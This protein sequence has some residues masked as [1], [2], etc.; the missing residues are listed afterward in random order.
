MIA[1]FHWIVK[2]TG[3]LPQKLIFRTKVYYEDKSV[4]SRRIKGK[5][6]LASNHTSLLDYAVIMF[7]FPLRTFRCLA[8]EVLYT[9][10][11]LMRLLLGA[12]GMIRVDRDTNDFSFIDRSRR[13]LDKNGVIEIYPEARL[14]LPNETRPLPFKPSAV[15]LALET[16]TPIIPVYSTGKLFSMERNRV[17]IGKPLYLRDFLDEQQSH[18]ENIQELT[19][20]LRGKIIELEQQLTEKAQKNE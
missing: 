4:Q 17:I 1:L 16:D 11:I 13:I 19:Q 7:L 12:L 6:I 9:K 2:I 3:W 8:A 18:A 10:G 20:L 14:P 5:A 15:Y